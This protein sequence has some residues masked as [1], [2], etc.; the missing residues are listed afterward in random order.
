[1]PQLVKFHGKKGIINIAMQMVPHYSSI[2]RKMLKDEH[3]AVVQGLWYANIGDLKQTTM[4]IL[5]KWLSGVGEPATWDQLVQ[6]LRCS[7][8]NAVADDVDETLI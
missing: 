1:M 7:D 4:A 8:L 5:K 6:C 3:G 2:G